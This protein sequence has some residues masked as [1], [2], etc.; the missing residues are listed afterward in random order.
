MAIASTPHTLE[1]FLR[2]PEEEPALELLDGVITQKVSP[3]FHHGVLQAELIK[4]I[5]GQGMPRKIA[6]AI[7]ELRVNF[8]H[9]SLVPDVAV[10]RWE[11]LPV[12]SKGRIADVPAQPPDVAIEIASPDQS[13]S[14]LVRKCLVYVANGVGLAI[15]VDPTD[16]S[17]LSF[18]PEGQVAALRS[19][20]RID[21]GDTLPEFTLTVDRLV[22]SL[23]PD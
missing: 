11:R 4:Q 1:E 8:P 2:I 18:R 12:D 13:V 7:P 23:R 16:E 9:A 17:V 21:L 14:A 3:K 20:D 22:A 6:R 5:D 15:L 10:Y 19:S